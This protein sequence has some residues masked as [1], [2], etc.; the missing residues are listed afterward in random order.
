MDA[1]QR[2][3]NMPTEELQSFE[4]YME[5]IRTQVAGQGIV[6]EIAGM[7]PPSVS[8][9]L[10]S[11]QQKDPQLNSTSGNIAGHSYPASPG[12]TGLP[13][14]EDGS[15]YAVPYTQ[16]TEQ[17]YQQKAPQGFKEFM[18]GMIGESGRYLASSDSYGVAPSMSQ[19]LRGLGQS[20]GVPGITEQ[21]SGL[22]TGG[23]QKVSKGKFVTPVK[24][25]S[26]L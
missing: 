8:Q 1:S 10:Q 12:K 23:S 17:P 6:Q 16:I 14:K 18:G 7:L 5:R 2:C 21:F 24:Y 22:H 13:Y 26:L 4:A 11:H 9:P 3:E 20:Q 25:C 15:T 19:P